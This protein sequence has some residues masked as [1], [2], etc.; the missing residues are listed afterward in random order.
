[1]HFLEA[2]VELRH[3]IFLSTCICLPK[4]SASSL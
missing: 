1:M 2:L 3:V 4:L